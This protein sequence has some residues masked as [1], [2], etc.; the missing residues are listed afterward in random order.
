MSED[1]QERH[2]MG[3]RKAQIAREK[4]QTCSRKENYHEE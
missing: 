1:R 4:R 3:Y 2:V